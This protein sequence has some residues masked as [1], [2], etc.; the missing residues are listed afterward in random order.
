MHS[1][2]A[3]LRTP[4]VVALFGLLGLASAMGIG[5]FAFTPLLPLMQ[6]HDGLTL[7]QGA[8]LAAANYLG[9][10]AGALACWAASLALVSTRSWLATVSRATRISDRA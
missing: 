6:Q 1:S 3:P 7:A 10:L 9:Y 5:R 8:W 4:F 2:G